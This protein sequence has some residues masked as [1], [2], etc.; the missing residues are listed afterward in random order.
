MASWKVLGGLS[1]L[2]PLRAELCCRKDGHLK[3]KY[4]GSRRVSD[5]LLWRDKRQTLATILVLWAT[6]SYF[7]ASGYT[8]IIAVSKLLVG[9]S[10]L[11]FLHGIS[12]RKIL[13][14]PIKKVPES[15]FHFSKEKS[16]K[17][18]LLMASSWDYAVNG[19]KSLCCGNEC[20][21]GFKDA[22]IAS[23]AG[24]ARLKSRSQK[25]AASVNNKGKLPCEP[26]TSF[27][28]LDE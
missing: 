24:E 3:R 12:Q 27:R 26:S 10:I 22:A 14:Y 2:T 23:G 13:G 19:L 5:I 15:K 7:V 11:L 28:L 8:I 25:Q 21:A 6:Y 16:H 4:L 1:T 18:A 17:D 20:L 9:A